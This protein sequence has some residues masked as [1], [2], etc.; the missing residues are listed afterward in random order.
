MR[1][2]KKSLTLLEVLIALVFLGAIFSFLLSSFASTIKISTKLSYIKSEA[3]A[4][5]H[6]HRRL[7]TLFLRLSSL[8]SQETSNFYTVIKEGQSSLELHFTV[9]GMI[10]PDPEF[11][12]INHCILH[13]ENEHL[14]LTV[15]PENAPTLSRQEILLAD[16]ASLQ[17]QF[18]KQKL[19]IQQPDDIKKIPATSSIWNKEWKQ[20]PHTLDLIVQR[21]NNLPLTFSFALVSKTYPVTYH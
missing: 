7:V 20:L 13:L 3:F 16:V 12:V 11:A 15:Y 17:M 4:R 9:K 2:N 5:F 10:D 21:H 6:L 8:Q 19:L 1:R 18:Y 14:L